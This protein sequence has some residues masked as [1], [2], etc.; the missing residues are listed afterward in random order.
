VAPLGGTTFILGW[1]VFAWAVL[2][3]T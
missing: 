2:R 3:T 1:G